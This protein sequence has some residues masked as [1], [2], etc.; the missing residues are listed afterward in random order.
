MKLKTIKL[1][2][3][4]EIDIHRESQYSF[5]QTLRRYE[6]WQP[7]PSS[8]PLSLHPRRRRADGP[9]GQNQTWIYSHAGSGLFQTGVPTFCNFPAT[10]PLPLLPSRGPQI[11]Q[12]ASLISVNSVTSTFSFTSHLHPVSNVEP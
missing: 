1:E 3:I 11:S 12:G 10:F 2:C 8:R 6:M 7:Y 9:T 5:A 4:D